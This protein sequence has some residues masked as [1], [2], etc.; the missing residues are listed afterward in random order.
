MFKCWLY[1]INLG[2]ICMCR[3]KKIAQVQGQ[4][5]EVADKKT[6]RDNWVVQNW[7]TAIPFVGGFFKTADLNVAFNHMGHYIFMLAG[8]VLAMKYEVW[9]SSMDDSSALMQ[10]KMATNMTIGM[11]V[12][13]MASNTLYSGTKAAIKACQTSCQQD[14]PDPSR[15][16]NMA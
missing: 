12:G 6:C 7:L 14:D 2:G 3:K 9:E 10:V 15:Y 4:E 1:I 11:M 16:S 8:D 13:E 5:S